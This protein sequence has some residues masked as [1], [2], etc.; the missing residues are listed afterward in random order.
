[1]DGMTPLSGDAVSVLEPPTS[2]R[3][4]AERPRPLN[5][6]I[7][8][9][10]TLAGQL[11]AATHRWLVL[12]AEFDRRHGWSTAYAQ[13]CAH[14]LNYQC[15]MDLG[16]A[17]EKVRVARALEQ[18]PLISAA[19]A[20]GEL[21]YSK[22]RALTRVAC[23]AT[24]DYLLSIALHATA[25]HVETLVR[26][27]RSAQEVEELSREARQ[28]Q[29]R[30]LRYEID[31]DGSILLR[32]SLPAE[33]GVLFL[34]ALDLAIEAAQ[35]VS[36]ETLS[37]QPSFSARRADAVGALAEAFLQHGAAGLG[38][39]ERQ[40]IVVHVDAST[41]EHSTAGRC[42]IED[43]PSIAAET[44]RRLSCDASLV[45]VL[46]NDLGEPLDIG[47]KRR[48][49][50]PAIRRALNARD[51]TCR[52]PGCS[53]KRYVDGH[54]I[55]HWAH[56]GGTVLTNLVILCRF[57]HRKVHEGG[58]RVEVLDDGALR[59]VKPNGEPCGVPNA[60]Q[61]RLIDLRSLL[62]TS[63]R[64]HIRIDARTALTRWQGERMDYGVAVEALLARRRRVR[65]RAA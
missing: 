10:T 35:D 17:R 60:E 23:A 19:M 63:Q 42:E 15:G 20:R 41:L 24:E 18:L 2:Q 6:L 27:Y 8:E 4:L 31:R 9:I 52:F 33:T 28:Q 58:I 36:A 65:N 22:V 50:P 5:T 21:S 57:H 32:A 44:A 54:H 7:A 40:Q 49:I 61:Q 30:Y 39:G 53:H 47:R 43:G 46:E 64:D 13:S 16:A 37:D 59:F 62:T 51:G 26:L 48:T 45:T 38:G 1:M 55:E 25:S 3:E 56:G 12:I 11:N 29:R 34:K 14:W